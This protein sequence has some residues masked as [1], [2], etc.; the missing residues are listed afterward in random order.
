[1]LMNQMTPNSVIHSYNTD[2]M[3]KEGINF[4]LNYLIV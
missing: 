2:N 1:M 3:L 4:K